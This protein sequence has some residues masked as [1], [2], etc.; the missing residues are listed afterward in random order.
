MVT[1][2]IKPTAPHHSTVLTASVKKKKLTAYSFTPVISVRL[3]KNLA[4]DGTLA[5]SGLL[6][7]Y[8]LTLKLLYILFVISFVRIQNLPLLST[9]WKI[10]RMCFLNFVEF[11]LFLWNFWNF[12]TIY[13]KFLKFSRIFLKIFSLTICLNIVWKCYECTKKMYS[14]FPINFYEV[15]I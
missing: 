7:Y 15:S 6:P 4:K 10:S 13:S 2:H 5:K 14:E 3:S 11:L 12:P 9:N 1:V 8:V